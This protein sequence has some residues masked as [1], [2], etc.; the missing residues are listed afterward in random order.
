METL[1]Q[2]IQIPE[3]RESADSESVRI[4]QYN[5]LNYEDPT[6]HSLW[7]K[8]KSAASKVVSTVKKAVKKVVNTVKNVAKKVV[9][10]VKSAVNWVKNAVTHPKQTIKNAVKTVQRTYNNVK[11]A[12]RS[13]G[14]NF[15]KSVSS[16]FQKAG[17]VFSS[18]SE[19]VSVK[20]SEIKATIKRELCTT[21]NTLR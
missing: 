13:A 5:P 21:A 19:Y 11:Q 7:S 20:T 18:F 17:R 14:S 12:A 2:R 15:V 9:N 4:C 8:I 10:T 6:G 3:H 1:Q 16:G